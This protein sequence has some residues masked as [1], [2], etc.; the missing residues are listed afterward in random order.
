MDNR[1]L[2]YLSTRIDFGIYREHPISVQQIIDSGESGL[3]WIKWLMERSWNFKPA[4]EVSTYITEKELEYGS[5][6]QP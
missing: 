3:N 4:K 6:L 5:V 2:I 1:K